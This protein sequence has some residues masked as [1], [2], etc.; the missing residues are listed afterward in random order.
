[1]K[2]YRNFNISVEQVVNK[3]VGIVGLEEQLHPAHR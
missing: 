3:S 1:M 2:S